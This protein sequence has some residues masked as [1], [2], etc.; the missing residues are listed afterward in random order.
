LQYAQLAG[1]SMQLKELLEIERD[2]VE[3]QF[4]IE[5]IKSLIFTQTSS[6]QVSQVIFTALNAAHHE[7]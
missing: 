3:V 2:W 6:I 4:S 5:Q 7:I 1:H